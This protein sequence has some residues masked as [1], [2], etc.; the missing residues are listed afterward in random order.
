[1]I[2]KK[3]EMD[4][5]AHSVRAQESVLEG[6]RD[7]HFLR[8]SVR[9]LGKGDLLR[10]EVKLWHAC[11]VSAVARLLNEPFCGCFAAV[12]LLHENLGRL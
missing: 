1:M 12:E 2:A 7:R 8:H 6:D 3:T 10:V 9:A 11:R 5:G 4:S